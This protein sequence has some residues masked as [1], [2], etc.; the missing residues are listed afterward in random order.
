MEKTRQGSGKVLKMEMAEE[1]V[2]VRIPQT[3]KA[4]AQSEAGVILDGAQAMSERVRRGAL[5]A[6]EKERQAARADAARILLEAAEQRGAI[7][8]QARQEARAEMQREV[9][10]EFR[11][12]VEEAV[13]GF[14][15]VV[16]SGEAA[17]LETLEAHREELITLA[18]AVA[19]R[20]I[21][22]SAEEDRNLVR[23]TV[24]A[25]L[26]AASDRQSVTLRINPEDIEILEE[27]ETD[28]LS[29]FDDLETLKFES[30]RRVDRGGAWVE[31]PSG[32]ID[33]R[34]RTQIAEIMRSV[35]PPEEG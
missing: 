5:A 17:F 8:E 26:K 4:E 2:R 6:A 34:I 10:Q 19:E 25:A 1:A 32:F 23:R 28:L 14:E 29:K 31:T 30:D 12:R 11:P 20:V 9:I 16:R 7:F 13:A 18:L 21:L 3:E 15:E 27:F 35:L 33:A 22:R 24:E